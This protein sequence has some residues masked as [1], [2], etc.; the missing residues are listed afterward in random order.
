MNVDVT[1]DLS[2]EDESLRREDVSC[3][4]RQLC[5]AVSE[6]C[7]VIAVLCGFAS[8]A[9]RKV[10]A[11]SVLKTFDAIE[12]MDMPCFLQKSSFERK[13]ANPVRNRPFLRSTWESNFERISRNHS[14]DETFS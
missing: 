2:M 7:A 9:V 10:F 8:V 11:K 1:A 6:V 5:Q 12:A 13:C 3:C 14:G 4:T